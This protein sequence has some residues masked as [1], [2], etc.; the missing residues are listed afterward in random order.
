M[1]LVEK[2]SKSIVSNICNASEI[3]KDELEMI[4]YGALIFILKS[5]NIISV[6]IFGVI[7]GVFLESLAITF[8]IIILRK[9]S[10]GVHSD[11]P[12]RCI[13]IGTCISILFPIIVNKIYNYIP[14]KFVNVIA[15]IIL[16]FS[17]YII[18][19][20]APVDSPAK[21]IVNMEMRKNLKNMSILVMTLI[22]VLLILLTILY[23]NFAYIILLKILECIC[24]G[25]F[26]QCFSLTVL[27]H[28]IMGKIDNIL[29]YIVRK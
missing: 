13:V 10:G 5:I 29:K 4:E 25:V 26:W 8:T 21:P 12:N 2:L 17:Y 11:S 22:S 28:V 18:L 1:F 16:I 14:F 3:D 6:I 20:L 15:I 27:G 9:Y 24:F 7:F 23:I 19:K